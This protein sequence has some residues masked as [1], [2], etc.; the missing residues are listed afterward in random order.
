MNQVAV[1]VLG[2]FLDSHS[3]AAG[4]PREHTLSEDHCTP[5]PWRPG[6]RGTGEETVSA[7]Q[8][9]GPS[10]VKVAEGASP[11]RRGGSIVGIPVTIYRAETLRGVQQSLQLAASG[12][13]ISV[14]LCGFEPSLSEKGRPSSRR[15]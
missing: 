10:A 4:F 3:R 8:G 11:G 6:V 15:V 12:F 9:P 14:L 1:S 7:P 13:F 5:K 2:E